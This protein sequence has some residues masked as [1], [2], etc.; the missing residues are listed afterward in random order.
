MLSIQRCAC[1]MLSLPGRI[2]LNASAVHEQGLQ[3]VWQMLTD[4]IAAHLCF[5]KTSDQQEYFFRL[6][7]S[8]GII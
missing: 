2:R 1:H 7:Q 6:V 8:N 5:H 3:Q 4:K